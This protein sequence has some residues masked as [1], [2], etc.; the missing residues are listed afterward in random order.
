[1]KIDFSGTNRI[2]MG[3][4]DTDRG[5]RPML[6]SV[7]FS[8]VSGRE[9]H[10]L[11]GQSLRSVLHFLLLFW[12]FYLREMSH[13]SHVTR[14]F[15]AISSSVRPAGSSAA[16]PRGLRQPQPLTRDTTTRP[17]PGKGRKFNIQ[18]CLLLILPSRFHHLQTC[19]GVT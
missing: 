8:S 15:P 7:E 10:H 12:G 18:A 3:V 11:L 19:R 13:D 6:K 2:W 17:R 5:R 14:I 9:G 16:A 4:R 1:M